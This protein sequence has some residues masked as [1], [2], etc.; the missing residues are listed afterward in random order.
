MGR[1]KS[2]DIGIPFR[3]AGTGPQFENEDLQQ[4]L[5]AQCTDCTGCF[6]AGIY[7]GIRAD[8]A[9]E[10]KWSSY[11][12]YVFLCASIH[13][14]IADLFQEQ[15]IGFEIF[16]GIDN[17][18]FL[19]IFPLKKEH[20][21][22]DFYLRPILK[23]AEELFGLPLCIGVGLS[24]EDTNQL[25]NTYTSAQ[26]AFE[27]YYFEQNQIIEFQNIHRDFT[28]A[29]ESYYD[30]LEEIFRAI[31]AKDEHVLDK[32]VSGVELIGAIHYGNWRAVAM[33]T[34]DYAG[35]LVSRLYRYHLLDGDFFRMQDELQEKVFHE[36]TFDGLKR[37]IREH[38]AELLKEAYRTDR[39]TGKAIVEKIKLYMQENYMENLSIKELSD[40]ACVSTNYF[41]H[42]FKRETGKNYKA[43]LTEIRMKK[44]QELLLETDFMIYEI[45]EMVGYN[46]T[47]TFT[48]AFKQT[49]EISPADFRRK[50]RK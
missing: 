41:S 44:A 8:L 18:R 24:A 46:N 7:I 50:Y 35:V 48:D 34:M 27:L 30:L 5:E 38:F 14:E 36:M 15:Q 42:M 11:Q 43:Y 4:M 37:C 31:L 23:T 16:R 2:Y 9:E 47:R 25:K 26:Y 33:R 39:L 10:I 29:P 13:Q 19:G 1:N 49:Y 3:N 22:V 6:F 17:S 40:I 20:D 45:S 32:I 21:F 28:V 12:Q